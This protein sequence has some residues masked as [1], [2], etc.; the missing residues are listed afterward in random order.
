MKKKITKQF[1]MKTHA[2]DADVSKLM[3]LLEIDAYEAVLLIMIFQYTVE[4]NYVYDTKEIKEKFKLT[5]AEYFSLLDRLQH[6]GNRGILRVSGKGRAFMSVDL[7]EEITEMLVSGNSPYEKMN[8]SNPFE[9]L[10]RF[11]KLL[12]K[13]KRCDLELD[14][15]YSMVERDLRAM[16]DSIMAKSFLLECLPIERVL[17]LY[18]LQ[19]YLSNN[20]GVELKD[21]IDDVLDEEQSFNTQNNLEAVF[22]MLF[23]NNLFFKDN[24]A[25]YR[26]RVEII[27]YPSDEAVKLMCG[28]KFISDRYC[29]IDFNN[30]H[31][32]SGYVDNLYAQLIGNR[33]N[34]GM[35]N[36]QISKIFEMMCDSLPLKKYM[37][38]LKDYEINI[39]ILC[40]NA[41][42]KEGEGMAL[43]DMVD[44]IFNDR[45]QRH[46]IIMSIL[47]GDMKIIK[48]GYVEVF[49]KKSFFAF[50]SE[51]ILTA[52]GIRELLKIEPYLSTIDNTVCFIVQPEKRANNLY[53]SEELSR[54]FSVL[55]TALSAG[56]YGKLSSDL[57]KRGLGG[58]FVCL[59]YGE[60]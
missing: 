39:L 19:S 57:K 50:S 49:V 30:V 51:L 31:S 34:E 52:R 29:S 48:D 13:R 4:M 10:D 46:Q 15:F 56:R 20:E 33:I 17:Y 22:P 54:E 42:L 44:T 12:K 7:P 2:A 14:T 25:G 53:F 3:K 38:Q 8:I 1:L 55:A 37:M 11:S 23:N 24:K 26:N 21:F 16:P 6:M 9:W 58:G 40:V 60:P 41:Y 18:V 59:F 47:N 36:A 27:I 35:Y 45:S 43:S 5:N 32:I 28:E